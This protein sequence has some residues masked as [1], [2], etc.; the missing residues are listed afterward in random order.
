MSYFNFIEGV[1]FEAT[2]GLPSDIV[3]KKELPQLK[4][5]GCIGAFPQAQRGIDE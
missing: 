1:S 2:T 4:Q 5:L 3:A